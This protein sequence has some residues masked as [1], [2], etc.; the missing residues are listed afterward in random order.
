MVEVEEEVVDSTPFGTLLRF[1][2]DVDDP[3]PRVLILAP[4]SG[5]FATLLKDT[6]VTMLPDHDVYITDWNNAR[7]VPLTAGRFG[8]DEYVDH[9]RALPQ[10]A[11]SRLAPAGRV[12]AVCAGADGHR[13]D[14]GERR[15]LRAPHP[16]PDGRPDRHPGQPHEGQR[17]GDEHV[18]S[19]GS[20]A[21]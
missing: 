14:G 10:R 5:H 13:G 9:V 11:R 1:R 3:G 7:D 8:F 16:D 17:P 18:R 12:P 15:P 20:S 19:S 2:K 4:L 6:V 21:T